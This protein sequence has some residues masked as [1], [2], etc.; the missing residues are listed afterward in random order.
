MKGSSQDGSFVALEI[1]C[2]A[3]IISSSDLICTS[4]VIHLSA[5]KLLPRAYKL[6]RHDAVCLR[7]Q[8]GVEAFLFAVME[9]ACYLSL[10]QSEAGWARQDKMR[11]KKCF[12]SKG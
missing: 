5:G 6:T 9:S 11:W 7:H 10:V 3:S 12:I 8:E 4:V 2:L 1:N